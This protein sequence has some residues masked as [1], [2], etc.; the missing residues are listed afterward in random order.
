MAQYSRTV[1]WSDNSK[2]FGFLGRDSVPGVFRHYTAIQD[3]G[4][5]TLEESIESRSMS[6]E[7]QRHAA[8]HMARIMHNNRIVPSGSRKG[9]S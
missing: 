3:N 6:F 7:H 1:K 4:H 2:E 9:L 5:K 8:N